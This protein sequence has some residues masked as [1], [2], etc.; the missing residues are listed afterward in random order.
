MTDLRKWSENAFVMLAGLKE[1]V[2][3]ELAPE[4][5]K[6]I[7]ELVDAYPVGAAPSE[8][9][10]PD[11]NLPPEQM[12]AHNGV[13]VG[14]SPAQSGE[15]P[16]HLRPYKD[17]DAKQWFDNYCY[18]NAINFAARIEVGKETERLDEFIPK[19][20]EAFLYH[21]FPPPGPAIPL[22]PLR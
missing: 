20:L 19:L 17:G 13:A 22:R 18:E 15:P 1:S 10:K 12:T 7:K 2:Q 5:M 3:W 21:F 6:E 4:I 16:R 14:L 9:I 11:S 8:G